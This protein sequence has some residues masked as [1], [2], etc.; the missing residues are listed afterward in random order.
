MTDVD[1]HP[2]VSD[3]VHRAADMSS[4]SKLSAELSAGPVPR[5][6]LRHHCIAFRCRVA[7]VGELNLIDAEA[8]T[9]SIAV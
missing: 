6:M 4:V 9:A 2:Y 5:E 1:P 3:H 8:H 7:K